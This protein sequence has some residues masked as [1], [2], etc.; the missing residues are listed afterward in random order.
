MAFQTRLASSGSTVGMRL[1]ARETVAME[2]PARRAT[3]RMLMDPG[4]LRS[5]ERFLGVVTLEGLYPFP[6]FLNQKECTGLGGSVL[7]TGICF[8]FS[9]DERPEFQGKKDKC[10]RVWKAFPRDRSFISVRARHP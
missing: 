10:R 8:V 3:S 6:V 9:A 1:T 2:T 4:R 7:K 5:D